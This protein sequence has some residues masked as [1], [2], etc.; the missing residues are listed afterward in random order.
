M[1]QNSSP[2]IEYALLLFF[3]NSRKEMRLVQILILTILCIILINDGI[4][5][6]KSQRTDAK[7]YEKPRGLFFFSFQQYHFFS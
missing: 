5:A 1:Q 2:F 4:S 3:Q 7:A 6:D